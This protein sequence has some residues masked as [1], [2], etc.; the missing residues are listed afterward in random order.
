MALVICCVDFTEAILI[1]TSFK[2]GIEL[3]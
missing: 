1:L 3:S 2:F